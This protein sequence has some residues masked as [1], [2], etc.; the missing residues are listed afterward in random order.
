MD[1]KRAVFNTLYLRIACNHLHMTH[2]ESG[3]EQELHADPPFSNVRLLVADYPLAEHLIK[4]LM[5]ALLPRRFLRLSLPPRMLM[6]PLERLEGG[7]SMVEER[8]LVELGRANGARKVV[9]H[10]G[11][12]LDAAGVRARL[13]RPCA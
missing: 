3:R 7:L 11:E 9:V 5:Q 1:E 8:M 2:L 13:A 4:R 12:T 10:V 6:H